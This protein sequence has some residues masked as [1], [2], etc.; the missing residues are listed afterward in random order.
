[1]PAYTTPRFGAPSRA[2]GP[3]PSASG[4]TWCRAA[5]SGRQ[6]GMTEQ[7]LGLQRLETRPLTIR[8]RD[9]LRESIAHGVFADGWLPREERLAEQ[10]GVSRTTIRTALRSLEEEGLITRQ[11]G[12]G[13][14]INA[15]IARTRITLNRVVG[16][17]DLIAEAGH[18]PGIAWTRAGIGRAPGGCA[19][20]LGCAEDADLA[21]V[22]RLFLADGEPAA[23]VVEVIRPD[24]VTGPLDDM[25]RS[26]FEF[27]ASRCR[28]K[29]D[30]TA[31]EIIPIVADHTIAEILPLS[32]GD[33]LL[34]LIETHYSVDGVPFIV[35]RIH[36]VD[37]LIRFSVVRRRF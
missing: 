19:T 4:S 37:R 10:V 1:V 33:P 12:V 21:R 25:P 14:R 35:A 26:V 9:L 31:V 23:H 8:A 18:Q 29:V 20:R 5:P 11:R 15:H 16:Y 27:A 30:H 2:G 3:E 36:V 32:R 6:G 17:W 13:T 22:D 34:R 24:Y 28:A 7:E